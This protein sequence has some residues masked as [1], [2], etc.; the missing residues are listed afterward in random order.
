MWNPKN[1]IKPENR[2]VVARGRVRGCGWAKQM[3]RVKRYKFSIIKK[4]S[5]KD[6][7]NV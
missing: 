4:I 2:L 7:I 6:V 1:K 5:H 3:K